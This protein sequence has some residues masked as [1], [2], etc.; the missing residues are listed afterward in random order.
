MLCER[1]MKDDVEC[2]SPTDTVQAAARKMRDA[3]VG[4]LPVCD[5][6][7]KVLGTVTDRDLAVRVLADG[8]GAETEISSV[9]TWEVIACRPEDDLRTA[10]HLM[11]KHRKSRMICTDHAGRL[12]GVISLS[13]VVQND[14][15]KLAA[16]TLR[17]VTDREAARL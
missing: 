8:L 1:I 6:T 9:M 5:E 3:N 15:S 10:E 16:Q 7:G 11:G 12:M 17:Q 2:V 4:F 14:G 13:D